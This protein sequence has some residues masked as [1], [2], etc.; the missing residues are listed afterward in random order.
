MRKLR[1]TKA[2][3]AQLT[4][5]LDNMQRQ[6]AADVGAAAAAAG[7]Y[8]ARDGLDAPL[9]GGRGGGGEGGGGWVGSSSFWVL[10]AV[11]ALVWSTYQFLA[12]DPPSLQVKIV[13][14][15]VAPVS[16]LVV[17]F[18]VFLCG[19]FVFISLSRFL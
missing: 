14:I 3:I 17:F 10:A 5:Q 16:W 4:E 13:L 9:A 7:G 15:L 19:Y 6:Y 1:S 8:L 18:L 12:M 2:E 11:G